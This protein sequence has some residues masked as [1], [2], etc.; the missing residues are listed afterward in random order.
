M[1]SFTPLDGRADA[2]KVFRA[3]QAKK[4]QEVTA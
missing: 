2:L 3:N 4:Q 1:G